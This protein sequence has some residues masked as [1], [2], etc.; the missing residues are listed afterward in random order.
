VKIFCAS[1]AFFYLLFGLTPARALLINGHDYV[2]LVGW[3]RANG[4]PGFTVSRSGDV[5]LT[6]RNSRLVFDVDSAQSQINGVSVRLTY[7]VAG[8]KNVLSV[9]QFD[10]VNTIRPLIYPSS[11]SAQKVTTICIDPGHGGK[12]TG[13]H[14]SGLFSRSEKTY[15]LALALELRNQLQKAGFKVVMTRTTD[16]FVTL[17]N[18]ADVAN[19]TG[20][21]LF[22]CLHFNAAQS[23]KDQ[24]QGPETYCIT[25]AGARSS[26]SAG[27]ESDTSIDTRSTPG[28]RN[29][30]P[31]LLLA[32]QLQKSLVNS[33]P[34]SDRG[35]KRARFQVLR[36]TKMPG[37]LLEGGFMTHP[38]EGKN[39]FSAGYRQ[40]MAAAIMHGILENQKLTAPP[41]VAPKKSPPKKKSH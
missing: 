15:T 5:V 24:V 7:P 30:Q 1:L 23:Q 27:E 21:D 8:G 31:S 11:S 19:R 39:I 41:A 25:P 9:S 36:E 35:V 34:V 33:L 32:Y 12:D 37:I 26:N 4:Y 38:V 22:I 16:T 17:G 6:N 3:A 14:I 10:I 28:N 29:E 13:E 2:P 18:R 20:A 40:R